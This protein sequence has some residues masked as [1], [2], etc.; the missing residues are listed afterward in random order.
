MG[1]WVKNMY[2]KWNPGNGNMD[3]NLRSPGGLS[4][5]H[6]Q[7]EEKAGGMQSPR[8]VRKIGEDSFCG[9]PCPKHHSTPNVLSRQA[10]LLAEV[11]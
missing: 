6:T 4:L 5:T 10:C 11:T 2:P 8:I 1:L 7:W 3:Q 9:W